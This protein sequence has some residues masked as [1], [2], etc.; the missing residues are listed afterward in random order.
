MN[1]ALISIM[2]WCSVIMCFIS[3]S[4][5]EH[6]PLRSNPFCLM[7]KQINYVRS[8]VCFPLC[9]SLCVCECVWG[10]SAGSIMPLVCQGTQRHGSL[11]SLRPCVCVCVSVFACVCVIKREINSDLT[12]VIVG[13]QFVTFYQI[14]PKNKI[15][16]TDKSSCTNVFQLERLQMIQ[17]VSLYMFAHSSVCVCGNMNERRATS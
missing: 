12:I 1:K 9:F 10:C 14:S 4:Q 11:P 7:L 16:L 13:W 2:V 5:S 3:L 6:V 17:H 15:K 8:L